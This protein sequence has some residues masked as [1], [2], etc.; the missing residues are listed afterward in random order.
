VKFF[1]RLLIVV[2]AIRCIQAS[3]Q[4]YS[5]DWHKVASGGGVSTGG[6]YSVNGTAGQH[7]AGGP[8]TGGSDS[9]TGGFWALSA[10][11][12][13]GAPLLKILLS[14]TNTAIVSW[15][16]PSA[17]WILQQNTSLALPA[18]W[19]NATNAVTQAGGQ[20]QIIVKPP[21]GNRFYRLVHP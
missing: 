14:N 15:P 10:V 7:D 3:A 1:L 12:T 18:G 17:G 20:N 16:E 2:L 6:V 19:S 9:I 4:T 11:Q 21:T 13:P 8:M 5:A